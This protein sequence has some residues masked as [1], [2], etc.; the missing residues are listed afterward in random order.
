MF[1]WQQIFIDFS[2]LEGSFAAFSILPN[3]IQ[4]LHFD[5]FNNKIDE[6]VHF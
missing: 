3:I 5:N 4:N 6:S 2:L 1:S